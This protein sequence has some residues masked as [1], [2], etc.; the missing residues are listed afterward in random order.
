MLNN[1]RILIAT[2]GTGGHINPALAVAG[3]I[4]K[5]YPNSEILFVGTAVKMEAQ[6]VPAAGYA[7]ET[8]DIQGFSRDISLEG[9]K[10]NI[11]TVYKIFK[12]SSQASEIIDR[13]K[14]DVVLGFGGYVSGPVLRVAEKKEYPLR[15]MSRTL[16]RARQT[17]L[18]RK[19][20]T[21]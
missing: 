13:F 5:N 14:P 4:R 11:A 21:G 20:R 12:A 10:K 15:Y 2:G 18:W 3:Y 16:S 17:R 8:I 7:F 9:V 6:L 1:K 19:K